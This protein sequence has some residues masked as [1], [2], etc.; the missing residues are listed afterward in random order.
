MLSDVLAERL[1]IRAAGISWQNKTTVAT[2]TY[3]KLRDTS[4][5]K[6]WKQEVLERPHSSEQLC[7]LN[8][9]AATLHVLNN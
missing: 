6:T 5:V 3:D 2:T 4:E 7:S 8:R 9:A 1:R